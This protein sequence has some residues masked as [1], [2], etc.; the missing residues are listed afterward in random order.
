[1]YRMAGKVTSNFDG[2]S[3]SLLGTH[4]F[5]Q[6]AIDCDFGTLLTLLL[7]PRSIPKSNLAHGWSQRQLYIGLVCLGPGLLLPKKSYMLYPM[8]LSMCAK[9]EADQTTFAPRGP[10]SQGVVSQGP[11]VHCT[12]MLCRCPTIL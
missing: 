6:D 10:L 1:V 5:W 12:Y 11:P 7:V 3:L 9:F 2:T 4:P 8:Q